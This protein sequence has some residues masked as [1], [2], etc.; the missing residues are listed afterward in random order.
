MHNPGTQRFS[1]EL[2]M[3]RSTSWMSL[4]VA[5]GLSLLLPLSAVAQSEGAEKSAETPVSERAPL[6]ELEGL[7]WYRS[8]DLSG[9]Q[10]QSTL[11][12]NEVTE[13]GTL[14]D[15][16]GVGFA[17]LEYTY[18]AAFDPSALPDM[19]GLATV[20]LAGAD[21][22]V[23][24]EVVVADIVAQVVSLGNDAPEPLETTIG[25]KDVTVV[26]L[27]AEAGFEDAIVYVQGDVA[28][29]F[30]MAEDLA[31]LALQQLP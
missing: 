19:G 22:D 28:Y 11:G 4:T 16:A 14:V 2:T 7:A 8:I 31:A 18:Q 26:S 5:L 25:D 17:D 29:V 12:E 3:P 23:L 27:P 30:L 1:K 15:G 20:R 24:L 13:W 10:I 6:P 9:P 21:T